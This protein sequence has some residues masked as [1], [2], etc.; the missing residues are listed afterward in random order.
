MLLNLKARF[1]RLFVILDAEGVGIF[2][3]IVYAHIIGMGLYGMLE[4]GVPQVVED[5]LGRFFNTLW[6]WM[7]LGALICE[8]GKMMKGKRAYLGMCMQ[9]G[10]DLFVFGVL[11]TYTYSTLYTGYWG[12]AMAGVFLSAALADCVLLLIIRD[13]RRLVLV[14]RIVRK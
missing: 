13:V 2:Q 11:A 3:A 5:S 9:F 1:H 14:E 10:G 7:C 8:V 6:L 12:K 4:A